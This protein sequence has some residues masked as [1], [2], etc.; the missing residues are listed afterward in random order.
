MSMKR[1]VVALLGVAA[2]AGL[3]GCAQGSA[4]ASAP[5]PATTTA[6][7]TPPSTP[8]EEPSNDPT[9]LPAEPEPLPSVEADGEPTCDY[10]ID[11]SEFVAVVYLIN[12]GD[13][14]GSAEVTAT[15]KQAN[16]EHIR[17]S[18]TV[19]VP[20]DKPVEVYLNAIARGAQISLHQ[21][22]PMDRRCSFD[23]NVT[24]VRGR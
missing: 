11:P 2:L 7:P 23:V 6:S 24:T 3:A 20:V 21:A 15:W 8:S 12:T 5:T 1:G 14:T 10:T 17:R 19:D 22:M 16:G 9:T 4:G 18:K 13:A